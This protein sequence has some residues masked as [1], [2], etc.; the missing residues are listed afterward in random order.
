MLAG[1]LAFFLLFLFFFFPPSFF[2]SF[3]YAAADFQTWSQ[4]PFP[5]LLSCTGDKQHQLLQSRSCASPVRA[6]LIQHIVPPLLLWSCLQTAAYGQRKDCC[7]VTSTPPRG[8][9]SVTL[10]WFT[11]GPC[12]SRAEGWQGTE[13]FF[14]VKESKAVCNAQLKKTSSCELKE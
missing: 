6:S 7:T 8:P 13:G 3:P 11:C 12:R 4:R 14:T 2:Q 10:C 5:P 9:N 1:M